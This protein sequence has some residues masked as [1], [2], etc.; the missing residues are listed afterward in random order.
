[1]VAYLLRNRK[2]VQLKAGLLREENVV[3]TD[4]P[5]VVQGGTPQ[6]VD[7]RP[8]IPQRTVTLVFVSSVS[9]PS[10]RAVNYAR[11]LGATETR[12]IYF[13]LDPEAAH[14]LKEEWFD[15]QM[16]IPLD[17]VEAPFR[18]LTGPM[19]DE[20]RRYT[21]RPDT[22]VNVVIPEFV[23]NKW[24]HLILHNMSALFIKR[25]FLFEERA[26][27]T[28]VPFPLE[29]PRSARAIEARVAEGS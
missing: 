16:G 15:S 8:L 24:R 22:V 4:V 21:E 9:D 5:V 10:I 12:A 23:I 1:L 18:D 3:V 20:V 29:D 27:L 26:V 14:R 7:A 11:S 25:L 6:G 13:E 2:L 19:V 17:I 28:S